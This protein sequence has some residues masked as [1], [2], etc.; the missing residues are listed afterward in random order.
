MKY[1]AAP[2]CI[3]FVLSVA[4]FAQTDRATLRGTVTDPT[5]SVVPN[6]EV[7]IVELATNI[8]AR[9]LTTDENGNFEMPGLKPG[10]YKMT[11]DAK[12]FR[13]YV[14]DNMLLDAGHVRRVDV[15]LQVGATAE[16][17]TVQAARRSSRPRP[18]PSP[19]SWTRANS[20]T[21]RWST[22]I[23]RRWR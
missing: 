4:M 7:T 16:T 3:L 8:E 17:I 11:V 5:G 12:G 23:P 2:L 10:R 22:S 15:S 18:A 14:A 19:A 9:R 1:F 13:S 6:V 20:S 21:G